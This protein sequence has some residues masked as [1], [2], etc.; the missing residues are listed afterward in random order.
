MANRNV[1]LWKL[2]GF[3]TKIS[4]WLSSELF[5]AALTRFVST[6][7][8]EMKT[9]LEL[10]LSAGSWTIGSRQVLSRL[11]PVNRP[12]DNHRCSIIIS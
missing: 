3:D 8:A 7:M 5:V 10:V 12:L 6:E 9:Q 2:L 11:L 4:E 1:S